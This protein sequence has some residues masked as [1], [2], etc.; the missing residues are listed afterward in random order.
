M[1]FGSAILLS[2]FRCATVCI[3]SGLHSFSALSALFLFQSA[4]VPGTSAE[5]SEGIGLAV[6]LFFYAERHITRVVREPPS[7]LF[8]ASKWGGVCLV[9]LSLLN[10]SSLFKVLFILPSPVCLLCEYSVCFF[11]WGFFFFCGWVGVFFC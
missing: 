2:V 1:C 11:L 10:E 7:P 4:S 5:M 3:F 8:E 9:S 6:P